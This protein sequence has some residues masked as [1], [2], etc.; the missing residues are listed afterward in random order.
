MEYLFH[1]QYIYR[2]TVTEIKEF[3]KKNHMNLMRKIG[4]IDYDVNF[5]SLE[6]ALKS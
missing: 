5:F 2:L 4:I 6:N 3:Q 1:Q